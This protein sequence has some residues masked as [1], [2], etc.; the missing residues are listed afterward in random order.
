MTDGLRF[1]FC[2]VRKV[3]STKYNFLCI[4]SEISTDSWIAEPAFWLTRKILSS[5]IK[6]NLSFSVEPVPMVTLL[7]VQP[8]VWAFQACSTLKENCRPPSCRWRAGWAAYVGPCKGLWSSCGARRSRRRKRMIKKMKKRKVEMK[9]E[10]FR[11][12]CHRS[13]ALPVAAGDPCIASPSEVA[14]LCRGKPL[15]PVL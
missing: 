8:A 10:G 13:V 12:P 14:R 7:S 1:V 15:K 4:P 2:D 5:L 9:E 11:G 6:L 3:L